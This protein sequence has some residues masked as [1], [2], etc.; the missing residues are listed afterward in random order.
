MSRHEKHVHAV[1]GEPPE[2]QGDGPGVDPLGD[3]E[4]SG[5]L[6]KTSFAAGNEIKI[7]VGVIVVLVVIFFAAVVKWM[8]HS[9]DSASKPAEPSVAESEDKGTR[10][11]KEP[12]GRQEPSGIPSANRSGKATVVPAMSGPSPDMRPKSRSLEPDTWAF[13]SDSH[14]KAGK[15]REEPRSPSP[16]SFQPKMRTTISGDRARSAAGVNTSASTG[17]WENDT[18]RG[19]PANSPRPADPLRNRFSSAGGHRDSTGLG[20]TSLGVGIP[21][22]PGSPA[23]GGEKGMLNSGGLTIP[24]AASRAPLGP[25]SANPLRDRDSGTLGTQVASSPTA[26]GGVANF[27]AGSR[28]A[29]RAT[30][31]RTPAA[32]VPSL[33]GGRRVYVVQEGDNLYDIARRELGKALR[34]TEIYELNKEVLGKQSLD[35]AVGTRLIL[36]DDGPAMSQRN[37]SGSRR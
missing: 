35:V 22:A 32:S 23:A 26:F 33:S 14:A 5:E 10:R 4:G 3:L 34:W 1:P 17:G 28:F 15:S 36:P 8:R 31:N 30:D 19:L 24:S 7:A 16:A 12:V 11:E 2:S 20:G 25:S 27:D 9:G 29:P 13:A 6:L 18:D 37:D 21:P